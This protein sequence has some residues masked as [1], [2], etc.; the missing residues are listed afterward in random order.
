MYFTLLF[1]KKVPFIGAF[2]VFWALIIGYSRIYIGVHYPLDVV[3]GMA[4]GALFGW[5]FSKLTI[6][7]F[8]KL[9]T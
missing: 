9:G 6:F 1:R 4:M 3:T 8:Q 2:L 7:A 5:V